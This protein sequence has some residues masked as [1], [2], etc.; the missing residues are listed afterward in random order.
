M[1]VGPIRIISL[2]D[3]PIIADRIKRFCV[4][5][6]GDRIKEY[7]TFDDVKSAMTELIDGKCDLFLLDL[8]LHGEDGFE[9]LQKCAS[10]AAQTIIISAYKDKA[11]EAFDYGVVDFIAKPFDQQR[12]RLALN[13]FDGH[14]ERKHYPRFLSFRTPGKMSVAQL[15]E[16]IFISG[17]DKY[18]EVHLANGSEKL[19]DKSLSQFEQMLPRTFERIHKSHIVCLDQIDS[20]ETLEGSRYFVILKTGDRL[21]VGRTRYKALKNRYL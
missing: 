9:I 1:Q 7:K 5:I 4:E 20:F 6:L 16:V 17:A 15:D 3:E 21:P 12:F 2:E 13:R 10:V 11:I 18:S 14:S 19:H 8:N